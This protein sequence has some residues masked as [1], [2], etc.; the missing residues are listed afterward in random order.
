MRPG[1]C[2][3]MV[4]RLCGYT[5]ALTVAGQLEGMILQV[6]AAV[7]IVAVVRWLVPKPERP[8]RRKPVRRHDR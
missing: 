8:S 4:A 7:G 5:V 6:T 3:R 2:T 1:W